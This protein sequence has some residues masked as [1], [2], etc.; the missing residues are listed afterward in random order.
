MH[1]PYDTNHKVHREQL[2]EALDVQPRRHGLDTDEKQLLAKD[3]WN[4]GGNAMLLR[5][6]K[7]ANLW[8]GAMQ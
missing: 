1:F 4:S 3:S 8:I 2:S 6:R 5:E 7:T